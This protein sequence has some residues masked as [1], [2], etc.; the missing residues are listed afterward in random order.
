MV[1]ASA[2]RQDWWLWALP[3]IYAIHI[4]EEFFVEPGLFT[5]VGKVVPF[6]ASSFIGVNFMI[7][8]I[9]AVAVVLARH[10]TA[11]RFLAIAVFTQFALHGLVVHPVWSLWA[12]HA[13]PGLLTGLFVLVPLAFAGFR[14]A[15]SI[16]REAT[17]LA[18]SP[19]ACFSSQARTCGESSST[20]SIRPP[21]NVWKRE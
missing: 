4:A 18:V 1:H 11:G 16:L 8:S 13:S 14:G 10:T 12:G 21:H 3:F 19:S 9:I 15:A 5:W 6:S 7:I 20:C 2:S 17:S